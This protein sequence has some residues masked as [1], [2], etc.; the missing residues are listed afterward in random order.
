MS[1]FHEHHCLGGDGI[2]GADLPEALVGAELDGHRRRVDARSPGDRDDHVLPVPRQPGLLADAVDVD[3]HDFVVRHNGLEEAL[4]HGQGVHALGLCRGV[5]V[6][7]ADVAP[8]QGPEDG[9]AHGV[10][11][12]VA[13]GV[14]QQALLEGYVD[15]ADDKRPARDE[16]VYVEAYADPERHL[17]MASAMG[18]SSGKVILML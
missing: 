14:S 4:E 15:P 1:F 5:G 9:V 2:A 12:H 3:V 13:V 10:D 6:E 18:M 11:H 7:D 8:G 16:P 17:R